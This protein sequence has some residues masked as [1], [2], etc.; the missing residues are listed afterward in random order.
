MHKDLMFIYAIDIHMHLNEKY[1]H[2]LWWQTKLILYCDQKT[3]NKKI[4]LK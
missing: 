4:L 2:F 3:S 1:E